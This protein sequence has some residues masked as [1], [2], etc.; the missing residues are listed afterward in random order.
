MV[1]VVTM[2]IGVLN[3]VTIVTHRHQGGGVP[4]RYTPRLYSVRVHM[5]TT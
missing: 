4:F 5:A 3:I 1:T 2:K